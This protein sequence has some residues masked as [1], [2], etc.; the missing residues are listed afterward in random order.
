MAF[1]RHI[2]PLLLVILVLTSSSPSS[3]TSSSSSPTSESIFSTDAQKSAYCAVLSVLPMG[4]SFESCVARYSVF[5]GS[6]CTRNPVSKK[7]QMETCIGIEEMRDRFL[8]FTN[9][10][11]QLEPR[12]PQHAKEVTPEEE[13]EVSFT[14]EVHDLV[15]ELAACKANV[16]VLER[17]ASA[18]NDL[19]ENRVLFE[20]R[21]RSC[22][23]SSTESPAPP[24]PSPSTTTTTTT[25]TPTTPCPPCSTSTAAPSTTPSPAVTCPPVTTCPAC[26]C[27][28]CVCQGTS[29]ATGNGAGDAAAAVNILEDAKLEAKIAAKDEAEIESDSTRSQIE[30]FIQEHSDKLDNVHGTTQLIFY[31]LLSVLSLIVL[32]VVKD[33][34]EHLKRRGCPGAHAIGRFFSIACKSVNIDPDT[35]NRNDNTGA[36]YDGHEDS[37]V[38]SVGEASNGAN[39]T[40]ESANSTAN[41]F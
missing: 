14:G 11:A 33:V 29:G 3:T 24:P 5:K 17:T 18:L 32:H 12:W 28:A 26:V 19:L 37:V 13:F 40:F 2:H 9:Q 27:A 10:V 41:L 35:L 34:I 4:I 38:V 6:H 30:M 36:A 21:S 25:S 20:A 8:I 31:T 22:P 1:V 39:D 15:D 7:L 16:T 23:R